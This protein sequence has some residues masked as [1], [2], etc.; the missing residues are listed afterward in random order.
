MQAEYPEGVGPVEPFDLDKMQKLFD[1]GAEKIT[2]FKTGSVAH[3]IAK[4]GWNSLS[5]NQKRCIRKRL[6]QNG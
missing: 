1:Q 5:K 2:V 3:R 6:K 4:E